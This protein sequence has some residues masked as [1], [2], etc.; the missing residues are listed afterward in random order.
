MKQKHT[1]SIVA[2][3]LFEHYDVT[4]YGFFAIL[5]APVFF[6]QALFMQLKLQALALLL[7]AFL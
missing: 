7:P 3:H 5:L 1:V 2:G 6:L 4:L